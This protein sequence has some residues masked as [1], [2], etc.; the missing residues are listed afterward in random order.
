MNLLII[1]GYQFLSSKDFKFEEDNQIFLDPPDTEV[2]CWV[3]YDLLL[4]KYK[5]TI[6]DLGCGS[7]ATCAALART[8]NS[9]TYGVD[10][11]HDSLNWAQKK[12]TPN[13]YKNRTSFHYFDFLQN[14]PQ[15]FSQR[16]PSFTPNIVI[17]NPAYVPVAP[18]CDKNLVMLNGGYDGLRFVPAIISYAKFFNASLGLTIGSYSCIGKALDMI[19][20]AEYEISSI[21]ISLLELSQTAQENLPHIQKL[22]MQQKA[23]LWESQINT[24]GYMII[25][26]AAKQCSRNKNTS[27]PKNSIIFDLLKET[28]MSIHRDLRDVIKIIKSP[29]I[30]LNLRI[31][32]LKKPMRRYHY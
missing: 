32:Q 13:Y 2:G 30:D 19:A 28:S 18:S 11:S 23:F 26:M 14:T 21:T 5:N 10:I 24:K 20:Q 22:C 31:L 25:G 12:Y 1:K 27:C 6:L 15:E 16:F 17:S 8:G 9:I 4:N 3:G 29:D 7:G